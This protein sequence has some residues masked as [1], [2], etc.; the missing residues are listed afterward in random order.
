[1]KRAPPSV[2]LLQASQNNSSLALLMHQHRESA[3]R[4]Q[5]IT[6]L[7]PVNLRSSIKAGPIDETAWCLLLDNN[8][9]AAK[10]RQLLPALEA[11]LRTQGLGVKTIRLKI[12]RTGNG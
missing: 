6:A 2:T 5:A 4:L 8:S 9:T 12:S 11:H 3:L 1:M 7:I 10:L